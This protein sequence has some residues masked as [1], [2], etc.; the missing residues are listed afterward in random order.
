MNA[1]KYFD[2]SHM[3]ATLGVQQQ[4]IPEAFPS[5]AG[6]LPCSAGA[7]DA[8]QAVN[9]NACDIGTLLYDPVSSRMSAP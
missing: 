9:V 7:R 3:P 1:S 2:L 6:R 4:G 8:P 5:S